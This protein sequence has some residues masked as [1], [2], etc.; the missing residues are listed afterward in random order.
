VTG[1]VILRDVEP[2]DLPLLFEHQRDPEAVAM[3]AFRSRDRAAFEA[4]WAKF[5][6]DDAVLKKAIIVDDQLV[7]SVLSFVRDEKREVGYW[8]DRAFWGRGIASRALAA[9]LQIEERRPLHAVVAR[10]NAGSLRVAQKCGF[11]LPPSVDEPLTQP[12]G[13]PVLVT[14]TLAAAE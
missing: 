9:F 12:D 5:L 11:K 6:S 3:A 8:I 10:H 2:G 1:E 14:L 7:G 13:S 4:H